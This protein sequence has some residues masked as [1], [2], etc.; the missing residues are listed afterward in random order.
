M[1]KKRTQSVG[2]NAI[3][4][5]VDQYGGSPAGQRQALPI[6]AIRPDPAQPRRLLPPDLYERLFAGEE[7]ATVL[8]DWLQRTAELEQHLL[9]TGKARSH[10][11]LQSVE[12]LRQLADTIEQHGLINAIT[13]QENNTVP[14]AAYLIITGER[15]GWAHQLLALEGKG[16]KEQQPV[17]EIEA[18]VA[19]AEAVRAL[20][21]IENMARDDLTAWERAAGIQAL[22]EELGGTAVTWTAVEKVLGISRQYR[23]RIMRVL[24]LDQSAQ[25]L[26]RDYNLAEKTI[27]PVTDRLLDHAD[28]QVVA[29]KKLIDWQEASEE[30]GHDR[31]DGFVDR[32]LVRGSRAADLP[33]SFSPT[34]WAATF[35]RRIHSTLAWVSQLSD[36]EARTAATVMAANK[37]SRRE[38]ALLREHLDW[39]LSF[40]AEDEG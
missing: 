40:P 19:P 38:L 22:R 31:L 37:E 21:L 12:K 2:I 36:A 3:F 11:L 13:V 33:P 7:P 8:H 27:R 10:P 18:K 20:Q 15:R 23:S 25:E 16:I 17:E 35:N 29:L 9:Q 39:M 24:R 34:R 4:D 6:A 26:V 30:S 14:G 1:A 32:L 28:L 5:Q